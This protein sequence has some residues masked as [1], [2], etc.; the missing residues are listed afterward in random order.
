LVAALAGAL[1][2][3]FLPIETSDW[4]KPLLI[5]AT[6]IPL[7]DFLLSLFYRYETIQLSCGAITANDGQLIA[8]YFQFGRMT[9]RYLEACWLFEK[10]QYAAAFLAF[11]EIR[12]SGNRDKAL[13]EYLIYSALADGKALEAIRL[14]LEMM[15]HHEADPFDLCRYAAALEMVGDR[16]S[17][18][19]QLDLAVRMAPGHH[20]A[21]NQRACLAIEAGNLESARADLDKAVHS[22]RDFAPALCNR[23]R[24]H[25]MDRRYDLALVDLLASLKVDAESP[26]LHL[27]WAGYYLMVQD[28]EAALGALEAGRLL[29]LSVEEVE[30]VRGRILAALE[31]LKP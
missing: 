31:A 12:Q 9:D 27:Q 19:L 13:Y 7:L 5:L 8:W 15:G 1:V 26:Q 22:Q 6:L 2:I 23:G 21:L 17:A 29:G 25:L 30:G 24:L 3:G 20:E 11:E 28:F 4:L 18:V 16:E 14:H 10:D